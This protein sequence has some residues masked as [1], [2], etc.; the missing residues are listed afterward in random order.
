MREE[1]EEV[2][3]DG[4]LG[5]GELTWCSI[6]CEVSGSAALAALFGLPVRIARRVDDYEERDMRLY[7]LYTTFIR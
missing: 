4:A 3:D 6:L 7:L 2:E 5:I 1:E